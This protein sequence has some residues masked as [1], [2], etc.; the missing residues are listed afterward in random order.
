MRTGPSSRAPSEYTTTS[1]AFGRIPSVSDG[2]PPT[3]QYSNRSQ[4]IGR[5]VIERDSSLDHVERLRPSEVD[6]RTRIIT[7]KRKP[8]EQYDDSDEDDIQPCLPYH[9]TPDTVMIVAFPDE[10]FDAKVYLSQSFIM[11]DSPNRLSDM[12]LR[13]RRPD[14]ILEVS[15]RGPSSDVFGMFYDHLV[16]RTNVVPLSIYRLTR[17]Q[18]LCYGMNGP[19]EIL[20]REALFWNWQSVLQHIYDF[21]NAKRE[22]VPKALTLQKYRELAKQQLPQGK[23]KTDESLTAEEAEALEYYLQSLKGVRS[24]LERQQHQAFRPPEGQYTPFIGTD[25]D[26]GRLVVSEHRRTGDLVAH[27]RYYDNEINRFLYARIGRGP[28][29][30]SMGEG[31]RQAVVDW[32]SLR[33]ACDKGKGG[34]LAECLG[35]GRGHDRTKPRGGQVLFQADWCMVLERPKMV[36]INMYILG[37]WKRGKKRIKSQNG[38]TWSEAGPN[39]KWYWPL[40]IEMKADEWSLTDQG[41]VQLAFQPSRPEVYPIPADGDWMKANPYC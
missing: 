12:W 2:L 29:E 37:W 38:E 8:E 14:K 31:A 17:V 22:T 16:D 24:W 40:Q 36:V 13:G 7:V 3:S 18:G 11:M 27:I 28:E 26:Y 21:I 15:V 30:E 1:V 39:E 10:D 25:W 32:T 20:Y 33:E 35:F 34:N 41:E 5:P 19:F 9:R 4:H 6:G 23:A